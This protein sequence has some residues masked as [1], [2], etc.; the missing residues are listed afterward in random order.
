MPSIK[1]IQFGISVAA[2][3]AVLTAVYLHGRH[4]VQALWDAERVATALVMAKVMASNKAR[5]AQ[6]QA[7]VDTART[8]M[9]RGIQDVESRLNRTIVDLRAG[10]RKLR[11]E[12]TCPNPVSG[13]ATDPARASDPAEA[14][15]VARLAELCFRAAAAGDAAVIQRNAAVEILKA[16][17]Q[18]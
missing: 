2:V 6:L 9:M 1:L 7:A 12:Y 13:A 4:D 18:P 15:P 3:V 17:R 11:A 8:D 16:E 14:D 10:N 5:E